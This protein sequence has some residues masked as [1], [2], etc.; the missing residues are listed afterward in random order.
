MNHGLKQIVGGRSMRRLGAVLVL[1]AANVQAGEFRLGTVAP[2]SACAWSECRSCGQYRSLCGA[3]DSSRG[4]DVVVTRAAL[5]ACG[6]FPGLVAGRIF[7][8]TEIRPWIEVN[9]ADR[10]NL[11]A[12]WQQDRWSNGGARGNVA[13]VSFDGGA[14]WQIVPIPG[15]TDCAGGPWERAS[16]PWVSFGPNGTVHQMS[17]VFQV[18]PSPRRVDGFG[19]NAL[20]VSK[21]TDGGS[22][23]SKPIALI[24]DDHPRIMNNGSSLTADPTDGNLVY[25]VWNRLKMTGEQ[26]A[27]PADAAPDQARAPDLGQG[28]EGPTYFARST[29]G[30]D[31]WEP[32]RAIYDPGPGAVTLGNRI[33]VL[34]DGTVIGIF[35]R[36]ANGEHGE[37]NGSAFGYDLSM[38]RS[39]DKG[40][41][42]HPADNPIR[43]ATMQSIGT[44]T[45]DRRVPVGDAATLF[46]VAVDADGKLYAVWQDVRFNG[47]EQ[48]AFAMSSDGGFTWSAP[49]Q[50]NRTPAIAG[51]PL[52]A[53]AFMPSVAV[54]DSGIVAVTYYDFRNDVDAPGGELADFFAVRCESSCDEP[55]RWGNKIRL[56]DAP[57][58]FL[59]APIAGRLLLGERQGLASDG[60]GYLTVFGVTSPSDPASIVFR[61]FAASP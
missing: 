37:A 23:W 43:A 3:G 50:V 46:D 17:L 53:Q 21:S 39:A 18:D 29:N 57:F 16:D 11:V 32:A 35:G 44:R 45:P 13:G 40:R 41:T 31:S 5:D 34:P 42:W 15:L 60:L 51:N 28:F 33:V 38:L 48:I 6:N 56:T 2:Q 12:I 47:M 61:R 1:F 24:D 4:A 27:T 7:T 19:R 20:L 25:A 55:A 26:T 10:N 49:I 36:A 52:R 9:R 59:D 8:D 58:D 54:T 22:H 14:A 30:G